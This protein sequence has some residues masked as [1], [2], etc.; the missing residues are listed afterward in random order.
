M[1]TGLPLE[2]TME[3]SFMSCVG[4]I[5]FWCFLLELQRGYLAV[6]LIHE[7]FVHR[8]PVCLLSFGLA[9]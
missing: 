5:C 8:L 9:G 1:Q 2:Y 6:E 3:E 4:C 7:A